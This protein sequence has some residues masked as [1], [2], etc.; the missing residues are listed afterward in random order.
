MAITSVVLTS[1]TQRAFGETGNGKE[2]E[3]GLSSPRGR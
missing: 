3:N 2:N 1:L